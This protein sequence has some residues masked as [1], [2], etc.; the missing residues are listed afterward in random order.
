M[1]TSKSGWRGTPGPWLQGTGGG[2][3]ATTFVY[4]VGENGKQ[5]SAIAGCTLDHVD[6]PFAER[7][8]NAKGI[9]AF[10]MLAESGFAV[11]EGWADDIDPAEMNERVEAL[12]AAL[13]SAGVEL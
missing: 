10:P 4:D 12:R 2:G 3:G 13:A 9:A 7:E 11:V 1:T 6:R 8:A 5:R